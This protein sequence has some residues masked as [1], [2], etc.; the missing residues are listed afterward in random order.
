M[1]AMKAMFLKISV[2]TRVIFLISFSLFVFGLVD[3]SVVF[4]AT[5]TSSSAV[6]DTVTDPDTGDDVVVTGVLKRDDDTVFAVV[7][8]SGLFIF[9]ATEVGDTLPAR[10]LSENRKS[11]YLS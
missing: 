5:P 2:K 9:T 3:V 11:E 6:G 4:A 10:R 1:G 7:T 8:D